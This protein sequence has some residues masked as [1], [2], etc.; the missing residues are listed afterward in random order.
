MSAFLRLPFFCSILEKR[1]INTMNTKINNCLITEEGSTRFN[2]QKLEIKYQMIQTKNNDN[3]PKFG[4]LRRSI[5]SKSRNT[6]ETI[7]TMR[8]TDSWMPR[9][10]SGSIVDGSIG[11]TTIEIRRN[12]SI[13][14]NTVHLQQRL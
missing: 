2:P 13:K 9:K 1:T 6:V 3:D 11:M 5:A 4:N 12:T 7:T 8:E 10:S 14:P